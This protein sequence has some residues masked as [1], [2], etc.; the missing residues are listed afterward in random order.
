MFK[1]LDHIGFDIPLYKK[2]RQ[3]EKL[4]NDIIDLPNKAIKFYND[5]KAFFEFLAKAGVK[6]SRPLAIAILKAYLTGNP[7]IILTD[8]HL[9]KALKDVGKDALTDFIG[10][11]PYENHPYL[12]ESRGGKPFIKKPPYF[13]WNY[14]YEYL[15]NGT[16][17]DERKALGQTGVNRLDHGA[18]LHDGIY[19]EW[20]G[21][22]LKERKPIIKKAD[23]ALMSVAKRQILR[24]KDIYE[25]IYSVLTYYAMQ[26]K[27]DNGIF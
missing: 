21:K 2:P 10:K 17:Y 27:I 9:R 13:F 20:M 14:A 7:A 12:P 24:P 4:K 26:F 23:D 8:E 18:Y 16:K 19:H 11:S 1:R 25:F 3:R 5:N 6:L 15:G 22:P